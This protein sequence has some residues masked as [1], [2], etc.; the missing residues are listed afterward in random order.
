MI[1]M[2]RPIPHP[3]LDTLPTG[4]LPIRSMP[5]RRNH[6]LEP[7]DPEF[8]Q[9]G[10]MTT[11][12]AYHRIGDEIVKYTDVTKEAH[13]SFSVANVGFI[14]PVPQRTIRERRLR[15]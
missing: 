8:L 10:W 14:T 5:G 12:C 9:S 4:D 11:S 7:I 3:D 13:G 15:F 6:V 2:S 1:A